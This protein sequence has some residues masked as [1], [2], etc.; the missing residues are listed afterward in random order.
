VS[1]TLPD[2]CYRLRI[3]LRPTATFAGD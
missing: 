1:V 3:N 2:A